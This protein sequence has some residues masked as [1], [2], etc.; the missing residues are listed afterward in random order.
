[1]DAREKFLQVRNEKLQQRR[2]TTQ[3]QD[4]NL[5]DPK[6]LFKANAI[7]RRAAKFGHA[8]QMTVV[9]ADTLE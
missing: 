8:I 6:E 1:M 7:N 9:D 3:N 5:T 2:E 4:E